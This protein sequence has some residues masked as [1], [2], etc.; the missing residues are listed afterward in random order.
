M[1]STQVGVKPDSFQSA[2]PCRHLPSGWR[3]MGCAAS[4]PIAATPRDAAPRDAPARPASTPAAAV[5][6]AAAAQPAPP[7]PRPA[8][9]AVSLAWL[10]HLRASLAGTLHSFDAVDFLADAD[11][12][13]GEL[14]VSESGMKGTSFGRARSKAT[15]REWRILRRPVATVWLCTAIPSWACNMPMPSTRE[16]TVKAM[17][18]TAASR[19]L[20]RISQSVSLQSVA[21]TACAPP[22]ASWTSPSSRCRRLTW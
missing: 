9:R 4:V 20:K 5:A 3:A 18:L 21:A 14:T 8:H 1:G 10:R 16:W 6:A 11:G 22:C 13:G 15:A 2:S 17:T 12:G 7:R 19:V